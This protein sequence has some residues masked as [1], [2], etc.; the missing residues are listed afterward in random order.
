MRTP[1]PTRLPLLLCLATP[2]CAQTH[3][4]PTPAPQPL[5]ATAPTSSVAPAPPTPAESP[6]RPAT[7]TY[8]DGQ[9]TV[10]ADNS[11][12]NQILGRIAQLTGVVITGGVTD[13]RV[14]GSYGPAKL[15]QVL[16]DLLDGTSSN[17]L[18]IAATED[19]PAQLIL[20][21]RNGGPT[22]PS[23]VAARAQQSPPSR[24]V[25]P[26]PPPDESYNPA[27]QPPP[28]TPRPSAAEAQPSPSSQ[29]NDSTQQSPNGVKTPQQIYN[30]LMR[31]RQQQQK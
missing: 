30:E 20:S 26:P 25:Y 15:S 21:S 19:K 4:P 14:F 10:K 27:T 13:E 18:F 23:P 22:P 28:P 3:R 12:L 7:V 16:N 8:T 6:A 11:S 5:P 31:L 1:R 9:L 24:P 2:L 17:M 29:S